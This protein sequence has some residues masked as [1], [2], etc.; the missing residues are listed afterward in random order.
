MSKIDEQGAKIDEQGAKI[1]AELSALKYQTKSQ[2]KSQ[3]KTLIAKMDSQG[4]E[5]SALKL[6]FD[7]TGIALAAVVATFAVFANAAKTVEFF[8][9]K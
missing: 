1:D 8:T 9:S 4:A 2:L 3:E 6:R 5:L 7:A